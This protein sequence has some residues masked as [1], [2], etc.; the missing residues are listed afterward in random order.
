[1]WYVFY[2]YWVPFVLFIVW[3]FA[4]KKK[5]SALLAIVTLLFNYKMTYLSTLKIEILYKHG[6]IPP[7]QYY[8]FTVLVIFVS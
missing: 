3:S 1:M 8:I 7:Q 5:H 4:V 6:T 2:L